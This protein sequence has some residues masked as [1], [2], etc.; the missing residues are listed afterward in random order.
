M[1]N[2]RRS[3]PSRAVKVGA[4]VGAGVGVLIEVG[5]A[6][7]GLMLPPGSGAALGAL[8]AGAF[9]YFTRGGRKGETD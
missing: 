8:L 7:A 6:A 9:S 2:K 5:A 4:P 3:A 1:M